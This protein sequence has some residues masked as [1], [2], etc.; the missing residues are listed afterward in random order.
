MAVTIVPIPNEPRLCVVG[1]IEAN[2]AIPAAAPQHLED[3]ELVDAY[4]VAL[5]DGSLIRARFHD[6]PRFEVVA[7]GAGAVKIDRAGRSLT[8]D[9]K[10]EWLG[11]SS[12][13]AST[14][15]ARHEPPTLPLFEGLGVGA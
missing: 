13:Y 1:D 11:V 9:W 10:I 15:V 2:L 4:F 14:A 8:V 12:D 5:S 7:E 6:E 3:S